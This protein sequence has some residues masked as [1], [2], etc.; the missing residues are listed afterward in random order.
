MPQPLT[1]ADLND[2][3]TKHVHQDFTRLAAG[4]T[5]GEALAWLPTHPPHERII[6]FY[7]VDESDRLLGVVPTR[8]LLLSPPEQPLAEIM[9]RSVIALPADATVLDACE[10]FIQHRLLALPVVDAD[11][12]ILGVVDVELY[13]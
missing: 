11:R 9:V 5:V 2:P 13:T 7:V 3:V 4:Q 12:R 6:Y 10:F 1:Q 8:R